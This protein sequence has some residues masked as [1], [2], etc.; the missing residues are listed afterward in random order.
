MGII[1]KFPVG[2]IP[3]LNSYVDLTERSG[4]R[5]SSKTAQQMSCNFV[6]KLDILCS[7]VCTFKEIFM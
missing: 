5:N 6:V 4:H 7:Y 3:I 2:I 1:P